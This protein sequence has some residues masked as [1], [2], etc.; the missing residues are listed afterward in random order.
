MSA[1]MIGIDGT[2]VDKQTRRW[3]ADPRVAGVILF[4]R[5]IEDR[6]QVQAL[7]AELRKLRPDLL[8]AV[9]QEGGRVRRLRE[10]FVDL[11]PLA[12]IGALWAIEPSLARR[13]ARLHAELMALDTRL[14]GFDF[15]FAPVAD[16]AGGNQCI[17]D[18]AFHP[19]PEVTARLVALYVERQ[20]ACGMA[21]T[22]KHFPGHGAVEADT[23]HAAA[24]DE[25]EL[26]QVLEDLLPFAAGIEAGARAV[27]MA[28]VVVPGID[29]W[30][31]GASASWIRLL[32]GPMGFKG[33]IV[34]DDLAMVGSH[35]LGDLP[36]RLLAHQR[37]G[38]DLLLVCKP[39]QVD[40][41]LATDM[42]ASKAC[43]RRLRMLRARRTPALPRADQWW[44]QSQA[45]LQ[46]LL[47]QSAAA[48]ASG[49]N[50]KEQAVG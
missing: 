2:V 34:C 26:S 46:G 30:P 36:A 42:A 21:A 40:A 4:A 45:I 16:V 20:Q 48:P 31:A 18:R 50:I 41:A 3:L 15:S 37:A 38:C 28:H 44:Q 22:L 12:Q 17:G 32:R 33:A 7:N 47:E 13:A 8:L 5:N 6:A 27:M 25:R 23:H 9:D 19:D 14:A 29:P 1:L 43:D 24:R 11:G 35:S 49:T 39:E 10:G